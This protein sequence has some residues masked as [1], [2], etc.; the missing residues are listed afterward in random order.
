MFLY[1][2]RTFFWERENNNHS[3]VALNELFLFFK[4][5]K[6]SDLKNISSSYHEYEYWNNRIKSI[7]SSFIDFP[8]TFPNDDILHCIPL[9]IL[10]PYKRFKEQ[11]LRDGLRWA[12]SLVNENQ[13]NIILNFFENVF[14]GNV[15]EKLSYSTNTAQGT[16]EVSLLF[17]ENFRFKIEQGSFNVFGLTK[18]QRNIIVPHDE[19]SLIF[20]ADFRQFE[21]RTF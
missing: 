10:E 5:K 13:W 15:L 14:C 4:I 3:G 1:E 16:K 12:Q 19:Q 18:N 2:G 7:I 21:F 20:M 9:Y 6:F 8:I 17:A 11:V